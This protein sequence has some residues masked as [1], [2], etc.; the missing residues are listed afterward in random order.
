[1]PRAD[2]VR[3]GKWS[4]IEVLYD[5]GEY[6]LIVGTWMKTDRAFGERWDGGPGEMGY[7][8]THGYPQ[9]HVVPEFRQRSALH[10]CLDTLTAHPEAQVGP[11]TPEERIRRILRELGRIN[12]N[13]H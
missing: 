2:E 3:P 9:F 10:D 13:H 4:E 6:S 7:P 1:M 11:D 12:R 5:D 8:S